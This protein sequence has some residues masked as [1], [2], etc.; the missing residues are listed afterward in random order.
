MEYIY[1]PCFSTIVGNMYVY[2]EDILSDDYDMVSEV[3]D[4]LV[5]QAKKVYQQKNVL[6]LRLQRFIKKIRDS[7]L[8]FK[9]GKDWEKMKPKRV[10][11]DPNNKNPGTP[12]VTH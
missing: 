10:A 2:F 11:E 5:E 8:I 1:K 7:I 6:L 12:K 4:F 9:Y 3:I